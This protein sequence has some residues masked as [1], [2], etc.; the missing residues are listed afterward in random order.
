MQLVFRLNSFEKF[1]SD[2]SSWT[3]TR[4]LDV[5]PSAF[6][7]REVQP[8]LI[9]MRGDGQLNQH[10]SKKH[11]YLLFVFIYPSPLY[12]A[13]LSLPFFNNG[14]LRIHEALGVFRMT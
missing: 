9:Y 5:N 7:A 2:H 1:G 12:L 6:L 14:G 11:I 13:S 3:Q 8:P 4:A 10:Q